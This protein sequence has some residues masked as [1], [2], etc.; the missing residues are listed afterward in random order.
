MALLRSSG[1]NL[2]LLRILLCCLLVLTACGTSKKKDA[3]PKSQGNTSDLVEATDPV[4]PA[5]VQAISRKKQ[6]LTLKLADEKVAKIIVSSS[7][8]NFDDIGVG[9]NIRVRFDD[10]V[11]IFPITPSGKPIW[12]EIKEIKKAPRGT[13]PSLTATRPY[14]FG[15]KVTAI[16]YLAKKVT[17]KGA[18][19]H[20]IRVTATIDP[21]R[22]NEIK[23]GDSVVAR[24]TQATRIEILPPE[25]ASSAL[26][27][28][29]RR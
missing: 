26:R 18:D 1:P 3:P 2:H 19:S 13:H 28:A 4:F 9:D 22:F 29:R 20:P 11:E 14:E 21:N 27:P 8:R 7:V 23:A 15:S 12:N 24:F 16:D 5:R 17:L 6:I 25:R 10:S